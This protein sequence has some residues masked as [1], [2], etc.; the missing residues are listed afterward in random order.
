MLILLLHTTLLLFLLYLK[1][2]IFLNTLI[3]LHIYMD[4]LLICKLLDLNLPSLP[5]FLNLILVSL[6]T[7]LLLSILKF[8]LTPDLLKLLNLSDPSNPLILQIFLMIS[9]LLIYILSLLL[10]LILMLNYSHLL[11]QKF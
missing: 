6:I 9:L 2:I 8:P 1:H 4:T 3:F 5:I 11:Y 7:T 10:H